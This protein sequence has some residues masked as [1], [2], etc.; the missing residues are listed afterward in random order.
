[1]L[2]GVYVLDLN[3][4]KVIVVGATSYSESRFVAFELLRD[5]VGGTPGSIEMEDSY[6]FYPLQKGEISDVFDI[7]L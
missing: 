5:H 3:I 6:H 4:D 7:S 2:D 1:M